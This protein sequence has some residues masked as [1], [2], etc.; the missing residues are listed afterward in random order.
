MTKEQ[1][2]SNIFQV[3]NGLETFASK[4]VNRDDVI[5]LLTRIT[6]EISKIEP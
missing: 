1:V 4:E 5:G 6:R 3:Q 2:I